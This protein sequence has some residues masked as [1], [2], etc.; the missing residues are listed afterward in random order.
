MSLDKT[1]ILLKPDA[2][3]RG[4]CGEVIHRFERSG[5]N[6]VGMKMVWVTKELSQKHYSVHVGKSFYKGLEDF[7][8]EF[9]VI[10]IVLE[11]IDAVENVR[12]IVG[13]T[14]PKK[15]LPGTIRGDFAHHTVESRDPR[16]LAVANLIHASGNKKE[17]EE[18]IKLWFKD[19]EIHKYTKLDDKYTF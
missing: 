15:A 19:E 14:E 2:L 13:H 17:A 11:G 1:L 16:G 3:Q 9:P 7:I 8:T 18:E 6:I 12:K 5:F 10:A 4:V